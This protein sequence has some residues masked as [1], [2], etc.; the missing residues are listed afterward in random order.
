MRRSFRDASSWL[1]E[2]YLHRHSDVSCT[3]VLW[4]L[5]FTR[6]HPARCFRA[7]LHENP[8][9]CSAKRRFLPFLCIAERVTGHGVNQCHLDNNTNSFIF[10]LLWKGVML[11]IPF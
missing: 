5:L 9:G 6:H 2:S 10:T 11:S 1:L 4:K 3:A 8:E 7:Y